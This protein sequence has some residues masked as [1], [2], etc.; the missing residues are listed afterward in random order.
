MSFH[1]FGDIPSTLE[2]S[3]GYKQEL[4]NGTDFIILGQMVRIAS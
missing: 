1:S 4:P 3:F 2:T